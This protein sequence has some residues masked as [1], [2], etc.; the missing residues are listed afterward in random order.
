MGHIW[1]RPQRWLWTVIPA[2]ASTVTPK[3]KKEK[4]E[5]SVR[6]PQNVAYQELSKSVAVHHSYNTLFVRIAEEQWKTK[7]PI[8]NGTTLKQTLGNKCFILGILIFDNSFNKLIVAERADGFSGRLQVWINEPTMDEC[9][10]QEVEHDALRCVLKV[11]N[12][13][14]RYTKTSVFFAALTESVHCWYT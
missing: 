9:N 2:S 11:W 7:T 5:R 1:M 3:E 10:V 14:Q 4:K 6:L 13:G 12:A 8:N